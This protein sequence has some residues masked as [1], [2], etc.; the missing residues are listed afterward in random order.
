[1]LTGTLSCFQPPA[2]LL[3]KSSSYWPLATDPSLRQCGS[4]YCEHQISVFLGAR[5]GA[6]RPK[7]A[8]GSAVSR[9]SFRL[10]PR[11]FCPLS[12]SAPTCLPATV[13]KRQRKALGTRLFDRKFQLQKLTSD[14][15]FV[16]LCGNTTT[17][18]S[19]DLGE[20]PCHLGPKPRASAPALRG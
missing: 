9:G 4:N 16:F 10:L 12:A 19:S 13:G 7:S 15:F 18:I 6:V 3:E 11:F 5:G 14:P 2:G 20:S 17:M 1:M 8:E